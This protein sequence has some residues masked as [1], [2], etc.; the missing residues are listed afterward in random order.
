MSKL[1][2]N[3]SNVLV[4]KHSLC[5]GTG[6]SQPS[7]DFRLGNLLLGQTAEFGQKRPFHNLSSLLMKKFRFVSS[8]IASMLMIDSAMAEPLVSYFPRQNLGQFLA[9]NFD[10]ATIRSS[11][12]P[13]RRS[14]GLRAFKSL[15]MKPSKATEN[16][17]VFDSPV[18]WFS[19]N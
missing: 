17:L 8:M 14:D 19:F 12:N 13:R 2:S 4:A 10:L 3:F 16:A 1:T 5:V 15:H 6:L 7:M 9:D 18:D 11:I